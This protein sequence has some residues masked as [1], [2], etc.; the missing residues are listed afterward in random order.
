MLFF[1]RP[2]F[3]STT[4]NKQTY[5]KHIKTYKHIQKPFFSQTWFFSSPHG[6]LPRSH[7]FSPRRS[8]RVHRHWSR[9]LRWWSRAGT[10][11]SD[12]TW[13]DVKRTAGD[14]EFYDMTKT[15]VLMD[16]MRVIMML[17]DVSGCFLMSLWCSM[18][19]ALDRS[20]TCSVK[21]EWIKRHNAKQV[22]PDGERLRTIKRFKLADVKTMLLTFSRSQDL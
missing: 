20:E 18:F 5:N 9:W 14:K 2:R 4:K 13:S 6:D 1:Q 22:R 12:R 19:Q 10:F 3:K 8:G 21:K 7:P 17:Y 16:K 11:S 15:W